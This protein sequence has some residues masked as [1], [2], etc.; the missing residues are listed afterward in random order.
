MAFVREPADGR[1]FA[2]LEITEAILGSSS[3]TL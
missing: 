3:L 2:A 1:P